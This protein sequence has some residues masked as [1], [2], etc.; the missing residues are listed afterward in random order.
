MNAMDLT[1]LS[2]FTVGFDRLMDAFDEAL[3]NGQASSNYPP[4]DIEKTGEDSYRIT[5]AVAS[6]DL[7]E[8]KVEQRENVLLI[9][10]AKKRQAENGETV[11]LH[12]GIAERDFERVFQLADYVTVTGAR[13]ENGLLHV[14][15][16]RELPEAMK[17][18]R[19][20]IQGPAARGAALEPPQQLAA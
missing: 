7:D 20:Q 4:Y 13:L 2:R 15:L 3:R 6:F 9:A 11:W 18:R 16:L 17:P 8:L 1:P 10:R 14:E 5:L 19:I 12:R